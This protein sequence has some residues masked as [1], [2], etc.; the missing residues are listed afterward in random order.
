NLPATWAMNTFLPGLVARR[1]ASSRIVALSTG[2][3]YAMTTP[4]SGGARETDAIA[5]VGEDA[6]S[7]L[8][9]ERMFSYE[10]EQRGTPVGLVGLNYD[11]ALRYGVATDIAARVLSGQPVDVGMGHVNVIWQGD[12]NAVT[13]QAFGLAASPPAVLNV[14]GPEI[15]SVRDVASRL[16]GLL[17]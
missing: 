5:P 15:A 3:V 9:R 1:Y 7:C 4:G 11:N 13:L 12:S 17:D 10:S 2:N 16:A 14:A 8:G 6:I